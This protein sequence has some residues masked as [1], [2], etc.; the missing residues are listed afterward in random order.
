M[1]LCLLVS[2]E[3]EPPPVP[4]YVGDGTEF[5]G[6]PHYQETSIGSSDTTGKKTDPEPVYSAVENAKPKKVHM[7]YFCM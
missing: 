7:K 6:E 3:E 5:S 4:P 2:I 1:N